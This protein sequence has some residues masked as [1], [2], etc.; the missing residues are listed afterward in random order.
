MHAYST[1]I[2]FVESSIANLICNT[3]DT[4]CLDFSRKIQN[5]LAI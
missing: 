5:R 2:D 1:L 3:E 4:S